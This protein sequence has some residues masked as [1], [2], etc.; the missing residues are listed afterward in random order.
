MH[1]AT[2]CGDAFRLRALFWALG[3]CAAWALADDALSVR[4]R[5]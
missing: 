4:T 3:R 2:S 1:F 5:K